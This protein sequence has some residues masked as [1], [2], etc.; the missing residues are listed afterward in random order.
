VVLAEKARRPMQTLEALSEIEFAYDNTW[1]A[2]RERSYGERFVEK[3]R[4]D[5]LPGFAPGR[6]FRRRAIEA[7]E[8]A[9]AAHAGGRAVVVTHASVIN[10]FL[11]MLLDV[12]RDMFFAP[13]H[14]SVSVVRCWGDLQ[15]VRSL[16]DTAH[17]EGVP[18][19]W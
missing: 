17:L 16:N 8:S 14:A 13:E 19:C 4:W 12:P 3:P 9:V 15:S 7:V 10:A 11:S 5:A 18:G 1:L 6:A 2:T